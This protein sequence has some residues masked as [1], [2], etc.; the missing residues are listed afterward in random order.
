MK[1]IKS[2]ENVILYNINDIVKISK[3]TLE[4]HKNI[5]DIVKIIDI[6]DKGAL[7]Y[8]SYLVTTIS[9]DTNAMIKFYV[10]HKRILRI[11]TSNEIIEFKENIIKATSNKFN[12]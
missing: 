5:Y 8:I 9:F 12:L 2:Y 1:Y 3:I 11:A 6:E 4:K 10:P 7:A